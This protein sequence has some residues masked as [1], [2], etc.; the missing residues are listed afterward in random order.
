MRKK[1]S[2]PL[3][4]L[5]ASLIACALLMLSVASLPSS[6]QAND[7]EAFRKLIAEATRLAY[8]QKFDE[9]IGKYFEAKTIRDD[10]LLDYNIARC[11]HKKGD[12]ESAMRF[13]TLV[14][15]NSASSEEDRASASEYKAELGEC[16]PKEADPIVVDKGEGEGEGEG[17]KKGEGVGQ[18]GGVGGD[19]GG[20]G[21]TYAAWGTTIAGGLVLLTGVGLDVGSAGLIDDYKAAAEAGDADTFEEL[22]GDIEDR[23][24]TIFALYGV[25]AAALVA[26][27]V[28]IVLDDGGG[29]V[30]APAVGISPLLSPG[31]AGALIEGR[32]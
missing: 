29:G 20:S 24:A 9:A 4:A 12:C 30:D 23:Q 31:A 6:A 22:S 19:E 11:Y 18:G 13:Y 7:T 27:V 5:C 16:K 17:D 2:T 8:E 21:F 32:W 1:L 15:E 28:M 14:L 10:P 25:G 3:R 26:G